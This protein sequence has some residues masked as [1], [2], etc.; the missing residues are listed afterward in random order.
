MANHSQNNAPKPRK[1]QARTALT[2]QKILTAAED[3]ARSGTLDDITAEAVAQ[4]AGVAKGTVFSH[5]GDM[6]GLL[7]YLLL[8]RLK[9][10]RAVSDA[11]GMTSEADMAD[12]LG[13]LVKRMMALMEVITSSQTMLRVFMENIGV[14]KGHCAPEFVAQLDALDARLISFLRH[15]QTSGTMT[16]ALRQDRTP[17]ELHDGLVAFIMHCAILQQ[18]RQVEDFAV[19]SHRLHRHLEAYLLARG[20]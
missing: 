8:D 15:W 18:S 16:P 10:L 14:T 9:D 3:I 19:I 12:P 7:S 4:A 1:P 20:A 13:A 17:E 11:D 2:R 6:D 5:F